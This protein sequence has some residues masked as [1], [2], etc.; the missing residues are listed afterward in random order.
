LPYSDVI[1][2]GDLGNLIPVEYATEIIK[3][4]PKASA[5]LSRAR[6]VPMSTK[7]KSQP[8]LS[9]LPDA[10]WVNGPTGL[11]STT[12][13]SWESPIITAEELAAIVVIPDSLFDDSSVPLWTEVQPYIVEALGKKVDEAAIFGVDKPASWPTAIIP[14]AT[15]AGNIVTAGTGTDIGQDVASLAEAIAK[16][17]F[18]INGFACRPGLNWSFVGLRNANGTPIYQPSLTEGIPGTLYGYPHNEVLNGAWDSSVAEI[19]AADWSKFVVGVRQDITFRIFDTGVISDDT[20]K[21]IV[22][23]LQQDSKALR[24]VFRVGFQVLN[25]ATRLNGDS[26]TRYPAG[27]VAPA[28]A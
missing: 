13:E 28:G 10:Y 17:G 26:A 16:D 1:N 3:E 6:Q 19:L 14:A 27:L 25:P 7:T 12:K 24:V 8:V 9:A 20:G 5:I 18:S 4:A 21:V 22:N 15:A 23:L 11:K 2:S